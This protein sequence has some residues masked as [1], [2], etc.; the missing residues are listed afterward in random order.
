MNINNHVAIGDYGGSE[1]G[2]QFTRQIVDNLTFIHG[3]HTF[4]TG[5][6]ISNFRVSSPPAAFGLL[7]GPPR[8]PASADSISLARFTSGGTNAGAEHAFADFLL[9]YPNS[10]YRSSPSAVNL[11]YNTT[12]AAYVQD[13]FQVSSRF[14]LN[15]RGSILPADYMERA[16]P[17]ASQLRL[18]YRKT[19]DSS[20]ESCRRKLKLALPPPI[21][22]SPTR[23]SKFNMPIRITSPHASDLPFRPFGDNKTVI[24]GGAGLY[25]NMLPVYIGFRQMGFSNPPFLLSET[26]ESAPG[27]TPSLTLAQPFP[28][29]ALSPEPRHHDRRES[30]QE[31]R[32]STME[33]Y[34]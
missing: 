14:T 8:M 33:P 3:K 26:F 32:V 15:L 9:G 27:N 1:R 11:F 23:T 7:S 4:K 10:T 12:Y 20:L 24:R 22:S 6:N 13:D 17:G 18:R 29:L 31:L 16:R 25:Y 5:I 21:R 30:D 34:L 28:E 19:R 2:K